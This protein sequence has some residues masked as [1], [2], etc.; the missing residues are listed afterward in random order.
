MKIYEIQDG[1]KCYWTEGKGKYT[2]SDGRVT[3]RLGF[4]S[5]FKPLS[6]DKRN[7][8]IVKALLLFLAMKMNGNQVKL[9]LGGK[10][11]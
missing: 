11:E 8:F 4:W 3:N 9:E 1:K 7:F 2:D 10:E 6:N 5:S